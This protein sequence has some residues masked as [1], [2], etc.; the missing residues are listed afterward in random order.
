LPSFHVRL[1]SLT[2]VPEF[3]KGAATVWAPVELPKLGPVL[4]VS[5]PFA[6]RLVLWTGV[7]IFLIK[8]SPVPRLME[9]IALERGRERFNPA[10]G[11]FRWRNTHYKMHGTWGR[12][13]NVVGEPLPLTNRLGQTLEHD[14]DRLVLRDFA[15]KAR[16]VID[17]GKTDTPW[18]V[19]G[20][21]GFY[22]EYLLLADPHSV[23]LFRFT[24]SPEGSGA[25]WQR[26][27]DVRDQQAFLRAIAETPDDDAPRLVYADWLEEHGDPDRAEFIRVQ[28]RL[29]ERERAADVIF[30]DPDEERARLLANANGD[31]WAAELPVTVGVSYSFFLAF[32]GFPLVRCRNPDDLVRH[33][34]LL[35]ASILLEAVMFGRLPPSPLARL[36]K[37]A[38]PESIGRLIVHDLRVSDGPGLTGWLT[39]PRAAR[40]RQ[41]CIYTC[42]DWS[43][44]LRAVAASRYLKDLEKIRLENPA[45]AAPEEDAVLALARSP[46]LPRLRFVSFGFWHEFPERTKAELRQRFPHIPLK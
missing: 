5:E 33:G 25:A 10:E 21:C 8:L 1:E 36:M 27:G 23:R 24:G 35:G 42:S 3:P 13:G 14:G 39:S 41:L 31:R 30:G 19:M 6:E 28:C 22:Q 16:Q 18:S 32:R 17:G 7:A 40:L 45:L 15:G 4:A 20:F 44:L 11:T 38:I 2:Y 29:A 43:G 46:H 26:G 37:T 12:A 34:A 9:T